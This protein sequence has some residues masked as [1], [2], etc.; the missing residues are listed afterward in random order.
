MQKLS[1]KIWP[2]IQD[3]IDTTLSSEPID[4]FARDMIKYQLES[5]GKRLRPL[6]VLGAHRAFGG[7][8]EA[9][10]PLAAAVEILHNASLVHDDIQDEDEYRRGR[11]AAWKKFSRA[12]AINLGDMLIALS[13]RLLDKSEA[14]AEV[15]LALVNRLAKTIGEMANGQVMEI[16]CRGKEITVGD[17]FAIV[18]G[19]TGAMFRL[20]LIGAFL[21]A[22]K[23]E[24]RHARELELLGNALGNMFQVRDDI[25][26]IL[27][28]KE[29]REPGGDVREGTIS[30]LASLLLGKMS[31]QEKC[32]FLQLLNGRREQRDRELAGR[33]QTVY[34]RTGVF[35]EA[36]ELYRKEKEKILSSPV[37]E[38]NRELSEILRAV[39]GHISLPL[40]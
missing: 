7:E 20:V 23:G 18:S 17:Y 26:D 5:G 29:G 24:R 21:L 14:T 6:L 13:F 38:E 40:L 10:V 19:K 32:D 22:G 25:L 8:D 16:A 27:G 31:R 1:E 15:R 35:A 11:P 36:F 33:L 12:Q 34:A 9:A 28:L 37:L 2:A 30:I 39:L 3:F 4:N